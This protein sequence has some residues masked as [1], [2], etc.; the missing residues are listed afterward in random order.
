MTAGDTQ[1]QQQA[2]ERVSTR[3]AGEHDAVV[4][5]MQRLE[6]ALAAA[7]PGREQDWARR[8][9]ADLR[10]VRS[11]L[12]QHRSSAEGPGG[13]FGELQAAL[14][15][16]SYRLG[17]LRQGHGAMLDETDGLLTSIER[18]AD[19]GAGSFDAIRQRVSAL[20]TGLRAHQAQEVDLIYEA[21][22]RDL[23]A[24]D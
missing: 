12:Q 19:G 7:A 11:A 16:A 2:H 20:L 23:G 9:G 13:L 18:M 24:P 5:A 17:K 6:G 8:V 14:P 21:F 22:C 3:T 10:D 15:A 4:V 1:V